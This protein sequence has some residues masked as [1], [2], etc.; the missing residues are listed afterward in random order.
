[1]LIIEK[2][3]ARSSSVVLSVYL[4]LTL[5]S[6]LTLLFHTLDLYVRLLYIHY[7]PICK[8]FFWIGDNFWLADFSIFDLIFFYFQV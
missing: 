6:Y 5:A 1:M 4:S 8:T 2:H 7:V 3:P